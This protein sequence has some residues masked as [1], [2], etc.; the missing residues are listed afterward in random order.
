MVWYQFSTQSKILKRFTL[1]S[2]AYRVF[3]GGDP[4]LF[5]STKFVENIQISQRAGINR[6]LV[7]S[8]SN[9]CFYSK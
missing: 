9:V 4:Y 6:R 3:Q 8:E 2:I 7:E 5:A 1:H